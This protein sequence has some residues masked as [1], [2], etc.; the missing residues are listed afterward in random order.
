M[1]LPPSAATVPGL[2]RLGARAPVEQEEPAG[3]AVQEVDEDV[4]SVP[5]EQDAQVE[6]DAPLATTMYQPLGHATHGAST[7]TKALPASQVLQVA[8][9][10]ALSCW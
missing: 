9:G 1:P 8:S 2:H 5:A 10:R 6:K 7:E 4:N 3:Q